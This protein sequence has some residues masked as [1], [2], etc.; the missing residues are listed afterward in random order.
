MSH[1]DDL[2]FMENVKWQIANVQKI[3]LKK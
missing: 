1:S 3:K 2:I